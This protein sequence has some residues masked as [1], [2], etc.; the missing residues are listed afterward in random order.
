MKTIKELLA[1]NIRNFRKKLGLT[2]AQLAEMAQIETITVNRYENGKRNGD[3]ETVEKIAAAL[4]VPIDDL[5]RD[6]TAHNQL[7]NY[8]KEVE[9]EAAIKKNME[10]MQ[11][12]LAMKSG[13]KKA[14]DS[15]PEQAPK[16]SLRRTLADI[17]LE[18]K[19]FSD[20]DLDFVI[21]MLNQSYNIDIRSL[22]GRKVS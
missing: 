15:S 9:I 21:R 6:P 20:R 5:Y 19:Y 13:Y 14:E 10:L 4:G 17:I 12:Y 2:Q 22:A 1:Q 16:D 11:E 3:P 18:G 8:I 7:S